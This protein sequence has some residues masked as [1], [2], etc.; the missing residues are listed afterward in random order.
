M[1]L[2][3][4]VVCNNH[5]GLAD[6]ERHA[7]HIDGAFAFAG[8]GVDTCIA[9]VAACAAPATES[10]AEATEARRDQAG[11]DSHAGVNL[12]TCGGTSRRDQRAGDNARHRA[13]TARATSGKRLAGIDL[14]RERARG[15]GTREALS[16]FEGCASAT[17]ERNG[18]GVVC[19]EPVRRS[20]VV[21]NSRLCRQHSRSRRARI[22]TSRE[23]SAVSGQHLA[24]R[25]GASL[26]G[27][28]ATPSAVNLS[29]GS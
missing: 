29:T 13:V 17:A 18:H 21:G 23:L 25:N 3:A 11:R 24:G 14:H 8:N 19:L 5:C 22:R 12:C 28:T 26:P 4:R 16:Q 27:R 1:A 20:A 10:R 6:L 9:R 2:W 15:R 7:S